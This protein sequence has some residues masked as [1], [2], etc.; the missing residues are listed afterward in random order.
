MLSFFT[1]L[2]ASI[3]AIINDK[4]PAVA[5]K[6]LHDHTTDGAICDAKHHQVIFDDA[7]LKVIDVVVKPAE[8]ETFHTHE[9]CA[10]MYVDVPANI[11]LENKGQEPINITNPK[12]R[13][14]VIPHEGLHR[15]TNTD[16]KTFRAFRFEIKADIASLANF[17]EISNTICEK[18]KEQ[19]ARL[20]LFRS[21]EM[22]EEQDK[23]KSQ[24]HRVLSFQQTGITESLADVM[25]KQITQKSQL[26]LP[27][28]F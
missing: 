4:A 20:D 21:K 17:E 16:N 1:S 27:K 18:I 24:A 14:A 23:D 12:Q 19:K 11:I 8:V 6:E 7:T 15:V 10:V 26:S 28:P 13:F 9:R 3:R 2:S 25:A 5:A 22:A